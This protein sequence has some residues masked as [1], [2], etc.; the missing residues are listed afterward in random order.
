M[1]L[2]VTWLALLPAVPT[3]EKNHLAVNRVKIN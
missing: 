1:Q 3:K 2:F